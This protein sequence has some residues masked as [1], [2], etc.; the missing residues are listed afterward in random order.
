MTPA[1]L[2]LAQDLARDALE[3][4]KT[5][6]LDKAVELGADLLEELYAMLTEL[7][8]TSP[9]VVNAARLVVRDERTA[10]NP[11][12]ARRGQTPEGE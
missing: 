12:P 7:L 10:P 5:A 3:G 1:D 11:N 4:L 2:A 6:A 8:R 9:E